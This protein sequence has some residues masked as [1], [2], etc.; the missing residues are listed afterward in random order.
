[1]S[2]NTRKLSKAM[3][4]RHWPTLIRP[5]TL[6]M[7]ANGLFFEDAGIAFDRFAV[8]LCPDTVLQFERVASS[9]KCFAA[10]E[11]LEANSDTPHPLVLAEGVLWSRQASLAD[12]LRSA[13]C[14]SGACRRT[15]YG[16]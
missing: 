10:T 4:P 1:M 12:D 9:P 13:F 3:K 7:H 16:P 11:I 2:M 5:A 15:R 14:H 8:R 6:V